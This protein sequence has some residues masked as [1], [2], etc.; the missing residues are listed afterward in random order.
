MEIGQFIVKTPGTCGGRAR[1]NG[2]RIPV[3]SI[4]R[5]FHQGCAPE[6]ML[7]KFDGVALAE[8]YA[9][10]SY[11][12]ANIEEI[13]GEIETEERLKSEASRTRSAESA[14]SSKWAAFA[15]NWTRTVK[16]AA[17]PTALRQH[18]VDAQTTN[19]L[20]LGGVDDETQLKA[21][22]E[23]QR[24]L[25]TN[26]ICDFVPLHQRWLAEGRVHGGII[27]FPQQ[28]LS[29]GEAVRRLVR[30]THTLS[31]EEMRNRLEWLNSW[32]ITWLSKK[33]EFSLEAGSASHTVR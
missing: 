18:G 2:K 27:V 17:W 15:F 23:A 20:G 9:A 14:R 22:A 28:E 12:L 32:G 33:L 30:L 16:R 24:V 3:S 21:A 31:A 25:V 8:I 7:E 1:L 26:S 5:W 29:I 13:T 19:Q 10:I 4:Y 6:D 11:A